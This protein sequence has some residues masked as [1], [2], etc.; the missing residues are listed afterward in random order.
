MKKRVISAILAIAAISMLS[1]CA[2]AGNGEDADAATTE[3]A[4]AEDTEVA[5]ADEDATEDSAKD[6]SDAAGSDYL[7]SYNEIVKKLYSGEESFYSDG[8]AYTIEYASKPGYALYDINDD[9]VYELFVTGDYDNEWHIDTIYFIKDGH[10]ERG[11]TATGY[12]P[13]KGEWI[14][15]FEFVS[16]A[17]T[18]DAAEGFKQVWELEYPF[19]GD[20]E[21][22]KLT[23]ADKADVVEMT[24]EEAYAL[25][26]N[27]IKEP[28]GIKWEALTEDTDFSKVA[29]E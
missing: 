26:A 11:I 10:A 15:G 17:Y 21:I 9:G 12:I 5:A 25:T 14:N 18:F 3:A 20:A 22:Y 8:E 6:G 28:E 2:S 1:G 29:A 13:D 24:Y 23:Y 27:M 19:D 4:P 7:A 16:N